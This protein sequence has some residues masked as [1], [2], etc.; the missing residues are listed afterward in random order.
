MK[1]FVGIAFFAAIA[2]FG[3]LS[4]VEAAPATA[5]IPLEIDG[6]DLKLNLDLELSVNIDDAVDRILDVAVAKLLPYIVNLLP[7]IDYL[8]Q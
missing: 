4:S 6:E 1:S 3:L 5:D 8:S 2:L 7:L